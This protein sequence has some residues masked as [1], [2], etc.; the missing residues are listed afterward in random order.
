MQQSLSAQAG[1]A[2]LAIHRH[3]LN[4]R[5]VA[6]RLM[7]PALTLPLRPLPTL[8]QPPSRPDVCWL[9][10]QLVCFIVLCCYVD[11]LFCWLDAWDSFP[12]VVTWLLFV[13][14]VCACAAMCSALP[15][16]SRCVI[17]PGH[18]VYAA[19]V[20]SSR[21]CTSRRATTSGRLGEGCVTSWRL[22]SA[23]HPACTLSEKKATMFPQTK[24]AQFQ[25]DV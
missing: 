7:Q 20:L 13:V 6:R 16:A 3:P 12:P 14:Y 24:M 5:C 19:Q 23:P 15:L 2:P 9:L 4:G 25:E 18:C 8:T 17:T 1:C 22:Q 10:C 11:A 21:W